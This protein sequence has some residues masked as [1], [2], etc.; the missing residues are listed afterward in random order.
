VRKDYPGGA[1]D[2]AAAQVDAAAVD[3]DTPARGWSRWASNGGSSVEIDR[4]AGSGRLLLFVGAV[5]LAAATVLALGFRSDSRLTFELRGAGA[6]A[7]VIEARR[8][9]ATVALSD[10]STLLAENATRFQVQVVGRN[11]AL[12]RLLAGK[13]HVSVVPNEDTSYRFLAGPYEVRVV[14]TELDLAW[15]EQSGLDVS[16]SKGE[17][18][19]MAP[20][21]AV[22]V[23][24][25]GD[26]VKLPPV[27][28]R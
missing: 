15:S 21:G 27:A 23:L 4:A 13:L 3:Q 2:A 26:A 25:A 6:Q 8:G 17:V 10:G 16:L 11:S 5:A 19:V 1:E 28:P 24:K 22:H 14:G 20:G 12:T 7:G 18:R 9:E